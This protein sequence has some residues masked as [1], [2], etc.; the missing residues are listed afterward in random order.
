MALDLLGQF[1]VPFFFLSSSFLPPQLTSN[2]MNKE[3]QGR[4]VEHE[5]SSL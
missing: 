3:G 5:G 1:C 2:A 4:I